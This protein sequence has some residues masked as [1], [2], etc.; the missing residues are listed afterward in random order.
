M[1]LER[2]HA[3]LSSVR[4]QQTLCC[5]DVGLSKLIVEPSK[6]SASDKSIY[7]S[8][9]SS[10]DDFCDAASSMVAGV[11]RRHYLEELTVPPPNQGK[12]PAETV[13]TGV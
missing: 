3:N 9:E 7:G 4:F 13:W 10:D 6:D 2:S 8:V 11:D 1:V 12:R 5:S